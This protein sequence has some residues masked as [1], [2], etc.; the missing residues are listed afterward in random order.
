M[1]QF[2]KELYTVSE[3]FAYLSHTIPEISI[4][5]L[6]ADIFNKPQI[7]ELIKDPNYAESINYLE[8]A[9]QNPLS[10]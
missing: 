6:K 2:G 4:E 8:K 7:R 3:Y 5:K 10:W 1:K 9:H